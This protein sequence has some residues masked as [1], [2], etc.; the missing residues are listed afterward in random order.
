MIRKMLKTVAV[1]ALCC[2]LTVGFYTP[3]PAGTAETVNERPASGAGRESG[4]KLLE[5]AREINRRTMVLDSHVDVPPNFATGELD[6]GILN[7]N[8]QVD[9]VKMRQGGM[10]GVFFIGWAFQG[11]LTEEGY[12]Q[13]RRDAGARIEAIRRLCETMYPDRIE[14]ARSTG[15]LSRIAAE[16]RLAAMIGLENGYPVGTDLS[17]VKSYYDLGVR[18]ITLC[19]VGHN[20]ICD[21][22]NRPL[23]PRPEGLELDEAGELLIRW[24]HGLDFISPVP[25]EPKH[26]GLSEFGRRVVAEMNRLGIIVDVSHLSAASVRDVLEVSRA[27]VIASHSCC[28]AL[29]DITRNLEDELMKAIAE[30][31]GCVQVTLVPAFLSFPREQRRALGSLIQRLGVKETSY[32]ELFKLYKENRPAYD[33]L[34]ES[35]QA[36]FRDIEERF[37]APKVAELVDH[38]DYAVKL[39]GSDHVG[40]GSDF[41]G[42]G[43]VPGYNSAAEA[44]NVTAELLRRGYSEDD[45]AKIWGGNLLRVWREVESVAAKLQAGSGN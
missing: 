21:S 28:R 43:G 6:P 35:F 25:P 42:G 32:S 12:E 13:G 39:I 27:P 15:E 14:L 2:W 33:E 4:K 7:E 22:A 1:P 11:P 41:G 9:L 18:Y 45:I 37:P 34:V 29:C 19:H 38:I 16:G 44:A 5:R 36:G 3:V 10:D 24:V 30:N 8:L 23:Q 17:R 31:G 20:Q 26:G 40:I